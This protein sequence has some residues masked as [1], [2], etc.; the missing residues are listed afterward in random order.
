MTHNSHLLEISYAKKLSRIKKTHI[1]WESGMQMNSLKGSAETEIAY[2]YAHKIN[3]RLWGNLQAESDMQN[4]S[5]TTNSLVWTQR[6]KLFQ[7]LRNNVKYEWDCPGSVD[8]QH[9]HA[10]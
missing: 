10:Y 4:D 6:D 3:S 7:L 8:Q 2:T 5:L 1:C 9:V